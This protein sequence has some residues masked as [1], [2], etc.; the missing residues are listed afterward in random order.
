MS[1]PTQLT[2]C[3]VQLY[4]RDVTL[5]MPF[6]FGVVT[7]RESPQVFAKVRIRLADGR[8]G[9]GH[10]AEMLA[11]KWFDKNLELSN[12]DNFD[13]LRHALTTAATLYKGSDPTT[14]FGLF[15]GNYDEQVRICD[16]RG[17]G[18]LVACYGPAVLDRAILDALCRLQGV[19]FYKA[20]QANLPGI[21]GEEFDINPFLSALRPS[22][23][24]HARHTVGMVDP[25]REN[26]E[27]VGDGLPE[28]LQEV[29]ATYGHRYFKIKVCGDLEEDVQRL[30]DIASVLDD[31]PNEYVISLDGN[32][33]YN[34]VAGVMELLDRIEGDA[35]LNRF[36]NSILFIEQP[37]SRAV[38]LDVDVAALSARKP[39]ILDESDGFLGAFPRGREL[40]YRGVSSK[41]CKGLYKSILNAARC[42]HWGE[43]YFMTGEDLTTQ[44]GLGVQQDLALVNLSGITHVERNGH[45]YVN[46][47]NG[48][49]GAEQAAFCSA[50]PDMYHSADGVARLQISDGQIAIGSLDAVGFAY[51][52]VPDFSV[53]REMAN[54]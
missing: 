30:Q 35:A 36:N 6:R 44:A 3:D 40:G 8:E 46:G 37:I 17:D 31:S 33:Q 4:E 26:P 28:T 51:G 48:V 38:A 19:S 27:P 7:L 13:Q 23:H 2:V 39:V 14:A 41:T 50:H 52:A 49:P 12:E 54:G 5:R 25:I 9:W 45:H 11:P 53:M 43:G 20:V 32:E 47:M 18:S 22:T 24:I 29:I 21:V 42:N 16:A 1:E 34:D 10:S 15:R